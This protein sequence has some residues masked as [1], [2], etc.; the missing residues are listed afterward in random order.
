MTDKPVLQPSA[1]HPITVTP[2]AGRAVVT[3]AGDVVADSRKALTVQ[4]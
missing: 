2:A 4:Q 1:K 3:V